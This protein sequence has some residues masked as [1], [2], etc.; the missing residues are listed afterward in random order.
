MSDKERE[1]ISRIQ[2][3]VTD[4]LGYDGEI[5]DQREK[6][7][8]YYYALPFGNEVDGRSQ[9][10]DSTVQD[11]IEWIKPTL[12]RIFGSGDEMVTFSP[13][14]PEDVESAKQATDYVNYVF[15]KDNPGW[16]ILYSWF[17]D[18]LLQ[19]NGIVKVWWDEYEEPQREEYSRLTEEE[20][21][22]LISPGEVEVVEHTVDEY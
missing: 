19:K 12:M 20:L 2:G 17:H 4:S 10:V 22:I 7:Q 9:F 15:T 18:A 14:G 16:E 11:T 6:A 21:N 1:L 13:F 8:E 5:A 3:E